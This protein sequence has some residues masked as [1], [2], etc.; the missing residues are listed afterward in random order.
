MIG[1]IRIFLPPILE[2]AKICVADAA[3][4]EARQLAETA[5]E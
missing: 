2:E 4:I 3:T 1:G 5:K